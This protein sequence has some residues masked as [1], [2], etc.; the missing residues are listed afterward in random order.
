M[1]WPKIWYHSYMIQNIRKPLG[2][3]ELFH[4]HQNPMESQLTMTCMNSFVEDQ[5]QDLILMGE[6]G[7]EERGSE[8]LVLERQNKREL[9]DYQVQMIHFT[10]EKTTQGLTQ[11][12]IS[13]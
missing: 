4:Q 10:N 6:A 7:K 13:F 12:H 2:K 8:Y 5:A 3:L 11:E 1:L 9:Q